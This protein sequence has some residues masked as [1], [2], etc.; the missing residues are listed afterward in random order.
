MRTF[1]V[2]VLLPLVVSALANWLIM[3]EIGVVHARVLPA[4]IPSSFDDTFWIVALCVFVGYYIKLLAAA[5]D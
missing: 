5:G 2:F 1:S 3:L 4:V